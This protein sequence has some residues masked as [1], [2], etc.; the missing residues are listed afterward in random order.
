MGFFVQKLYSLRFS[1]RRL[2][3]IPFFVSFL[4]Y[5]TRDVHAPLKNK[6]QIV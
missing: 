5:V 3:L 4:L 1:F 2:G 6:L